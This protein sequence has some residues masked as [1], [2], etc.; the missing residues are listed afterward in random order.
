M[1]NHNLTIYNSLSRQKE[2]F[3]S[4]HEGFAGMYVCGPTVYND[5]HLGNCRTFISFDVI[6]RYLTY[7]G[8]TVRYVRNI[9]DVGHLLD[10]GEDRMS[11]GA[12]LDNLEPMEVAQKYTLGFHQILQLFN[13]L[14]P[15]IEPRATGHI[16]EQIEMVKNILDN[17][18]AYIMNGS[19]YFD[20]VKFAEVTGEY[21]KLS[22]RIIEE[23]LSETRD[24]LKNQDEKHHPSDFAIWMKANEEHIMRWPSPWSV[25]FPGWHL[26]CSAMSTKYLGKQFDIH[27]GGNDLKFP[28]HENEIAQ[29]LGACN[30]HPAKYWVHTNMLLMNGRKMSKS[31][32][33]TISPYELFTGESVHV[34][35]GYSPMVVRFFMLQSHYRST[36]DLTDD[37]LQAA[38]KGYKRLMEAYKSLSDLLSDHNNPTELD[39]RI[40]DII[41]GAYADMDDDFNTPRAIARLFELVTIINSLK[42]GQIRIS[43]ISDTG[44]KTL[45]SAFETIIFEIFG[46]KEENSTNDGVVDGLMQLIIE[47]RQIARTNKEWT[48]ADKIRDGLNELQIQIKDGKDGSSWSFS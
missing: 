29:N 39:S 28:H 3:E 41:N 42:E 11:K 46:L 22:G 7:L 43:E 18:Y 33:N 36:N 47:L 23:L 37:A 35:K 32:G 48:T 24:N 31:D 38:E 20:T 5:V 1:K 30:I 8:Y 27:G 19:V 9:T 15:S 10:D 44:I 40:S 4:L 2:K 12:R 21:G 26:E 34:S 45:K 17:G 25:G 14:P 13:T 16:I 6:Y